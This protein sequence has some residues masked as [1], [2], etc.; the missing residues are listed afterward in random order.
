MA[1]VQLSRFPILYSLRKETKSNIYVFYN[2]KNINWGQDAGGNEQID[3]N[4]SGED[5]CPV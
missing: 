1:R 5:L 2:Y 3:L 4:N